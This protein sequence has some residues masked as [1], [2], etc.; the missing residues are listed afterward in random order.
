MYFP[1]SSSQ[2]STLLESSR[3]GEKPEAQPIADTPPWL[4][5]TGDIDERKTRNPYQSLSASQVSS[6]ATANQAQVSQQ[7][8]QL[9]QQA[10][11]LAKSQQPPAAT[12]TE[13]ANQ[14]AAQPGLPPWAKSQPPAPG[15]SKFP[16]QSDAT[17]QGKGKTQTAATGQPPWARAQPQQQ[18]EK[19]AQVLFQSE[20]GQMVGS[21]PWSK[22][23]SSQTS[24][25]KAE[26]PWKTASSSHTQS[27][28]EAPWKTASS[29]HTQ[30]L[31]RGETSAAPPWATQGKAQ[32][33]VPPWG[34]S[35]SDSKVESRVAASSA[36]WAKNKGG[37]TANRSPP[38]TPWEAKRQSELASKSSATSSKKA[39]YDPFER[40][41]QSSKR[42]DEDVIDKRLAEINKKM[43][44]MDRKIK[45][46][47]EK[48]QRRKSGR[49]RSRSRSRERDR[50]RRSRSRE[51]GS[52][53]ERSRERD[54]DQD[55]RRDRRRDRS[56]SPRSH[57]SPLG[58]RRDV[59]EAKVPDESRLVYCLF[60]PYKL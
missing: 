41:E 54:R 37:T 53:R 26:A 21:P 23:Q 58:A 2:Q 14:T 43:A 39:K 3:A 57:R 35:T 13:T 4:T 19:R 17:V 51:R 1:A 49:D 38:K 30:S 7:A 22:G 6:I 40:E 5:A 24:Q 33:T 9:E 48:E 25:K 18:Q 52:R 47:E 34:K 46:Y 29:S 27:S 16:A 31:Q 50:R 60:H 28:S 56:R 8:T 12:A 32:A 10:P 55:D 42:T 44:A 11:W 36:P 20:S 15:K 59:M 45:E